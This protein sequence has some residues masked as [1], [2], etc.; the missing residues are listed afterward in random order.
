[1][2][3]RNPSGAA[4]VPGFPAAPF[5]LHLR[6]GVYSIVIRLSNSG[7]EPKL[8]KIHVWPFPMGKLTQ[9]SQT[10]DESRV[11]MRRPQEVRHRMPFIHVRRFVITP[12]ECGASCPCPQVCHSRH[13]SPPGCSLARPRCCRTRRCGPRP[14]RCTRL[15][16]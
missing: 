1:M 13:G 9:S 2:I 11:A 14:P 5:I 7:L 8:V 3:R 12:G 15:S 6:D 4:R 16:G 10:S